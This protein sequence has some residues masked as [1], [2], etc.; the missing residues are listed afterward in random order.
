MVICSWYYCFISL[1]RFLIVVGFIFFVLRRVS[2]KPAVQTD[3][4]SKL[5]ALTPQKL[6]A[7]TRYHSLCFI[8]CIYEGGVSSWVILLTRRGLEN[9]FVTLLVASNS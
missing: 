6:R 4:C 3:N 5:S 2:A 7:S 8:Q 1:G 9:V